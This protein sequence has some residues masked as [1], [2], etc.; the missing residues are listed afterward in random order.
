MR[1]SC[2]EVSDRTLAVA[3]SERLLKYVPSFQTKTTSELGNLLLGFA[4]C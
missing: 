2:R 4:Q 3:V 1:D